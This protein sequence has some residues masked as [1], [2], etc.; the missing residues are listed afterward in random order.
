[1]IFD[2]QLFQEPKLATCCGCYCREF[3]CYIWSSSFFLADSC[4]WR[5]FPFGLLLLKKRLEM[6]RL[7]NIRL[8]RFYLCLVLHRGDHPYQEEGQIVSYPGYI[9]II[10]QKEWRSKE[11]TIS[12]VGRGWNG[13]RKCRERQRKYTQSYNPNLEIGQVAVLTLSFE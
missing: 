4:W 2:S 3:R 12:F 6:S 7:E 1:M 5:W 8:W 13:S 9:S 10:H 11:R